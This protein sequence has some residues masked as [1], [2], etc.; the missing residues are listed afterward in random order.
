M[1]I[2]NIFILVKHAPESDYPIG[3]Y[4]SVEKAKQAASRND[5]IHSSW[6]NNIAIIG[7]EWSF[8]IIPSVL[9]A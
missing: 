4:S 1:N 5:D 8:E 9:D 6:K 3:V 2:V 7:D